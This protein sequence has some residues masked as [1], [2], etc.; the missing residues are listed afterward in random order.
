MSP[1]G[2]LP[3][4]SAARR[5]RA[6]KILDAAAGLLRAHGYR[7]V[8]IDDVAARAGTGKGTIYLH[9]RSREALFW[10]VLQRE[11]LGL[12]EKLITDLAADAELALPQ[13]LI[14]RIFLELDGR[15]LVRA[16]LMSDKEILGSLTADEAVAA[17]QREMTGQPDYLRL[18]R[19]EGLLRPGLS[20]EAASHVLNCLIQGFFAGPETADPPPLQEQA[21][22]LAFVLSRT[23]AADEPPSPG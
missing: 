15:P 14:S 3:A 1:S 22:L 7:R 6:G 20:A 8:S 21:D 10:S 23:L 5:E 13:R 9:W 16:L 11:T 19:D 4:G 18:L 17:A 12:L 2:R